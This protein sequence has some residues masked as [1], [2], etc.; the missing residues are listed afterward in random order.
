MK[1]AVTE[2]E[3]YKKRQNLYDDDKTEKDSLN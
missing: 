1:G 2:L 3:D